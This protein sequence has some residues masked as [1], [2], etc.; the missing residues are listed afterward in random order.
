MQI[1]EELKPFYLVELE[2][3]KFS[4]CLKTANYKNDSFL[5]RKEDGINGNGYDWEKICILMLNYQFSSDFEIPF[6]E[7][8]SEADMFCAI[9]EDKDFLIDFFKKVKRISES[10]TKLEKLIMEIK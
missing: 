3:G 8:D 6:I 5:K 2:E 9:S 1:N 10:D 4:I 7:F